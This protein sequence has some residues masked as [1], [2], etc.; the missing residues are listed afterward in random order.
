MTRP[1]ALVMQSGGCTNVLNRSLYGVASEFARAMPE[2]VL[3]GAPHGFEGMLE[4]G[5][6]DLS[7]VSET[8]W[9]AIANA[10]GAV[11]GSTRRKLRDGDVG[12][13][14]EYLDRHD[15][16]YWFI[17][18]GN[19]SAETGHTLQDTA[20][21]LGYDLA[22]VNAPK[23]IDNDLVLTDHCPGYGSAARFVALATM[24]AGRDAE[25][26]RGASPITI[27]EVMGRDAGWLAAASALA[28]RDERDAPHVICV[29][30]IP[31]LADDFVARMEAAY[32]AY[33]FAVAV[34]S[35]NARGLD[36]AVLGSQDAP[37][38][39]AFVDDFGHAYYDG[40]ARYLAAR[41]SASLGVRVRVDKPGSIQRSFIPAASHTDLREAEMVGRAAVAAAC[42]DK[43]D[44]MITLARDDDHG[45]N[46]Y[47]ASAPL[48]RVGGRVR[49]MPE[50]FLLPDE[51]FVTPDFIEYAEPLVGPLPEL[52]R[53]A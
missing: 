3:Y 46:C 28:R 21:S 10:P 19:D 45:Y 50:S 6:I 43:R 31:I 53:I 51:A 44:I 47:T 7:A 1:N 23:T 40:P 36:G 42:Q 49:T 33:G 37:A 32:A 24:G 29:P 22:V 35:E 13:I 5:R 27:I 14:F 34:I 26:M 8:Q 15:I 18:G 16:G 48:E 30:E 9:Q 41:L 17:I 38:S 20:D 39:P 12:P 52:V 25:A 11:I 2:A 4:G